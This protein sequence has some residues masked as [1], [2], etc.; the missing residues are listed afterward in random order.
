MAGKALGVLEVSG[1]GA[2]LTAE[3]GPEEKSF[4]THTYLCDRRIST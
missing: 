4:L 3:E 2:T 1:V